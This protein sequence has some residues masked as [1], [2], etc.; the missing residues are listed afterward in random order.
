M[1]TTIG[2]AAMLGLLAGPALAQGTVAVQVKTPAANAP[3]YTVTTDGYLRSARL[4]GA[5]VYDV[6]DQGIGTID[7]LLVSPRGRATQAVLSVGGILGIE[8]RLVEVPFS[9]L[10]ISRSGR[11]V[12]AGATKQSVARLPAYRTSR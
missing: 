2:I 10:R 11:L 3:A 9:R 7:D 6:Q 1:R 8:S 12:L 4:I 5:T